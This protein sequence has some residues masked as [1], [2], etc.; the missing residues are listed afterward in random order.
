MCIVVRVQNKTFQERNYEQLTDSSFGVC[1]FLPRTCTEGTRP[2]GH[3]EAHARADAAICPAS[4][5][6]PF[7]REEKG[8]APRPGRV[9][10]NILLRTS[11]ARAGAPMDVDRKRSRSNACYNCGK[12]GHIA[13][14]CRSPKKQT[15][16]RSLLTE[17][18]EGKEIKMDDLL[19]AIKEEDF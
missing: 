14:N 15:K 10:K 4:R 5:D 7:P 16:V 18:K 13:A 1:S 11:M 12:P 19:K 9:E 2:G 17:L 3:E 6:R 8:D